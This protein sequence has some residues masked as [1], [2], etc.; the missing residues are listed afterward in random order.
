[1]AT[2]KVYANY[3]S[4]IFGTA[5]AANAPV[6]DWLSDDIRV[7]LH[8]SGYV[9]DL[10][11]H[12]YKSSL[13]N[14]LPTAAGY[15]A[16]GIALPAK[17][18]VVDGTNGRVTLGGGNV[19]WTPATFTGVRYAVILDNTPSTAATKPLI[20]LLDLITDQ[21]AANNIFELDWDPGGIIRLSTAA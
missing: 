3:Q 7:Q 9:P 20:A 13:T 5:T 8:T 4:V 1:M 10:A 2:L 21:A 17:T 6:S 12:V 19:Q 14:E 15:T 18:L 11:N 16:G